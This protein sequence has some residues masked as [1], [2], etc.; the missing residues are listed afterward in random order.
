MMTSVDLYR[1]RPLV[2]VVVTV[3]VELYIFQ[4]FSS[5]E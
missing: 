1:F 3:G 2:V 5:F 4:C